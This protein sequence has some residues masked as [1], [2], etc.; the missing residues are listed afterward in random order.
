MV[1]RDETGTGSSRI[2]TDQQIRHKVL[3][4]GVLSYT[5]DLDHAEALWNKTGEMVGER[6]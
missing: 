3:S 1:K 5:L 4:P 2:V 6:Y